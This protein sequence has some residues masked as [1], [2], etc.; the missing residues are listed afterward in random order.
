[1]EWWIGLR[2]MAFT[3]MARA[4]LA[5]LAQCPIA[6]IDQRGKAIGA[7]E[8]GHIFTIPSITI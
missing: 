8:R 2:H 6:F 4:Q 7:G 5:W 3:S 1:M